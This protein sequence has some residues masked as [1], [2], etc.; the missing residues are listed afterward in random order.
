GNIVVFVVEVASVPILTHQIEGG[1]LLNSRGRRVADGSQCVT[2]LR[3]PLVIRETSGRLL[4]T[5]RERQRSHAPPGALERGG[6][7]LSLIANSQERGAEEQN[8]YASC[9]RGTTRLNMPL[10]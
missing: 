1:G 5:P 6:L 10:E 4:R 9:R 7:G 3:R 2:G 8:H